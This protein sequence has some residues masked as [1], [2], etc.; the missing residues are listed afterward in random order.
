MKAGPIPNQ[1][2]N[3]TSIGLIIA[4]QLKKLILHILDVAGMS[5]NFSV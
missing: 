2:P 3:K 4:H 5:Y 1:T